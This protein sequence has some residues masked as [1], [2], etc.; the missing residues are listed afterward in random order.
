M[1]TPNTR[2][3]SALAPGVYSCVRERLNTALFGTGCRDFYRKMRQ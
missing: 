2:R 3:A 1:T